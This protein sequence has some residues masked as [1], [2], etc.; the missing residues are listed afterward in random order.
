MLETSQ[1]SDEITREPPQALVDMVRGNLAVWKAMFQWLEEGLA[2]KKWAFPE[3]MSDLELS[4]AESMGKSE[5][6]TFRERLIVWI[7]KGDGKKSLR[8]FKAND[9][10]KIEDA[11]QDIIMRV[12]HPLAPGRRG[13]P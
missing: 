8:Q 11:V 3:Q 12:A 5:A 2:R 7:G 1:L 13:R 9:R 4:L 10:D 6:N